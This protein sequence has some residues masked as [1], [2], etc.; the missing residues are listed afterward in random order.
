MKNDTGRML[1]MEGIEEI[2][3]NGLQNFSIRRI[4]SKCGVSCALPYRYF[5]NRDEFIFEIFR[6]YTREWNE[7]QDKIMSEYEDKRRVI[8]EV[9]VAYV[10]FLSDHPEYRAI[11][12][13]DS[14]DRLSDK[15]RRE[16]VG[17]SIRSERLVNKYCRSVGMSDEVRIRK[18]FVVRSVMYGAAIMLNNGEIESDT[19]AFD[20]VR[21]SIE[22]EFDLG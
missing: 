1:L 14:D 13:S 16:I 21:S 20:I 3:K 2:R 22:R 4:A 18:T 10:K 5:A 11:I 7:I 17:M 9:S 8:V 12:F 6:Y 19:A 15:Q